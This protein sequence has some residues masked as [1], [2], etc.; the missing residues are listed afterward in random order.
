MDGSREMTEREIVIENDGPAGITADLR[1]ESPTSTLPVIILCHGFLG[2]KRW[3]WFP[4]LSRKLAS[5][6]FH[7]LTLSFSLNGYGPGGNRITEPLQ[8][9]GN[10]VSREISDLRNAIKYTRENFPFPASEGSPGLFG[11]SRGGAVSIIV[12]AGYEEVQSL[13]TWSTPSQLDRYTD[14]RKKEWEKTGKLIFRRNGSSGPLFLDYSY[15][16]DIDSNRENYNLPLQMSRIAAPHLIIHGERD[17]AVTLREAREL[18]SLTGTG[19]VQFEVIKGAGHTFGIRDPMN[20]PPTREL[21]AAVEKTGQWFSKTF[22]CRRET[23]E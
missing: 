10:T 19:R 18:I 9:A 4:Y 6:G 22:A 21:N 2:H 13:V 14:R 15:Y 11:H 17:A 12:A 8:F 1:T 20:S 23:D 3:G 16:L 5:S 7:T